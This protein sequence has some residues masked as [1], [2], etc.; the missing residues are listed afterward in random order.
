MGFDP[1]TIDGVWGQNTDAAY[2]S[3]RAA[4]HI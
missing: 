3:A 2:K 4:C 1:G